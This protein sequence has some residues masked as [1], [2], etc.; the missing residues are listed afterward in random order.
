MPCVVLPAVLRV[1]SAVPQGTA[2][3]LLL[4][5]CSE[6]PLAAVECPGDRAGTSRSTLNG[7]VASASYLGLGAAE[8]SAVVQVAA[9][10]P[11]GTEIATC[12]GTLVART[13]VLSAAHCDPEAG[14][15]LE[16]R[17]VDAAG[18]VS[19]VASV[20]RAE[21][22]DELDLL[23]LEVPAEA[24]E[25]VA[26]FAVASRPPSEAP[27][28]RAQIGGTGYAEGEP[29]ASRLFAVTSVLAVTATSVTVGASGYAGACVGD[30][31][32]PLLRR[33]RDGRP[34]VFG[35]LSGGSVTCWAEDDYVRTDVA[36]SWI[37]S[38]TGAVVH[39]SPACGELDRVGR[40][41]N[42]VAV[43]CVDARL[44]ATACET[45]ETCGWSADEGGFR[46]V[47]AS[48]DWC[49][50]VGDLGTCSDGDALTCEGGQLR[51]NAC[52]ACGAPCVISPRS[53]RA[54][55]VEGG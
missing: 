43:W 40:C 8:L 44:S 39:D 47:E 19:L 45:G 1:R 11:L 22:L 15:A 6:A 26:P 42:E 4:V 18:H 20:A 35:V 9:L 7:G 28:D 53:G 27:G 13:F 37:A 55:C 29:V 54:T 31:G 49:S 50:G 2:C 12:T 34:E 21:R 5:A 33:N 41:F 17:R 48:E 14:A 23:L 36:A 25:G 3:F 32:G 30:S 38:V 51:R 52:S 46:C 10:D 24:F 16:V